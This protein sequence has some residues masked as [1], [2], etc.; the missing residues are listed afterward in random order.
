MLQSRTLKFCFMLTGI[1]M[2]APSL[3]FAKSACS[4]IDDVN[5]KVTT[6][7]NAV[8]SGS[9][10]EM[11]KA[12]SA[13]GVKVSGGV[14]NASKTVLTYAIQTYEGGLRTMLWGLH[15]SCHAEQKA[16]EAQRL[17][18]AAKRRAEELAGQARKHICH[19]H[20]LGISIP[21]PC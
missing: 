19:Y 8:A 1:L 5:H 14:S 15:V 7:E 20:K 6:L 11:R 10:D 13:V 3:A 17:A 2:I 16:A 18:E 4:V 12:A 9:I 21:Y